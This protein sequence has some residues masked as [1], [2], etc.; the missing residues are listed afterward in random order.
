MYCGFAAD[1]CPNC[2]KQQM[3]KMLPGTL[4]TARACQACGY[5]QELDPAAHQPIP[6]ERD[7]EQL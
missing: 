7:K 5:V 2:G 3:P 6:R 1:T 4:A